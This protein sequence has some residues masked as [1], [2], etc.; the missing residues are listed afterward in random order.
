MAKTNYTKVEEA[1]DEGL[2]KMTVNRLLES[3]ESAK[4]QVADKASTKPSGAQGQQIAAIQ[5]E[6]KHLQKQGQKPYEKLGIN[7][8]DIKR[9]IEHPEALTLED[10]NNIK[11]LKEKIDAFK[12][13]LEKIPHSSDEE[14]IE[15]E[16]HK[17]INKRFNVNEKWLPLT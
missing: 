1:L 16:R 13:E 7:K 4:D 11:K 15:Q 6:L 17:H 9:Y 14:L 8:K 3:T 12:K 2:R 5:T 10:W